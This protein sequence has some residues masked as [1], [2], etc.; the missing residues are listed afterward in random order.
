M[1]AV[2]WDLDDTL[3]NTLGAR[4]RAVE[5]AYHACTGISIDS[6]EIWKTHRGASIEA[7]GERLLGDQAKQFV[8]RF[9]QHYYNNGGPIAPYT[10]VTPVLEALLRAGV[11]MVVI[12]SKLSWGATDELQRCGLLQYFHSVVGLDD[13]DLHRPEPEPLIEALD[14]LMLFEP[15]AAYFV[16][17]S[18]A[19][20]E[21]AQTAGCPSIGAFWGTLEA[22]LL[23]QAEPDYVARAPGDVLDIVREDVPSL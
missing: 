15:E 13:T 11:P 5:F 23:E 10:G 6:R 19:D 8:Q 14:R 1:T 2:L 7:L 3:L 18:P 22:S 12:T 21:A 17:D 9:Q 20:I 16:G 4:M